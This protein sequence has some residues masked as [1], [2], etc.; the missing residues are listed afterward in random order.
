MPSEHPTPPAWTTTASE[1]ATIAD[2]IAFFTPTTVDD[3]RFTVDV[4]RI[5]GHLFGGIVAA[6]SLHAAYATVATDRRIQSV[7]S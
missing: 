6:Q 2:L 5:E 3:D 7:H 4:S 1:A